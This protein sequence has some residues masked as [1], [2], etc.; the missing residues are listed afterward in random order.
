VKSACAHG[1]RAQGDPSS[2]GSGELS[3]PRPR[4]RVLRPS[5][6]AAVAGVGVVRSAV[7]PGDAAPASAESPKP[8]EAR[9]PAQA[10]AFRHPDSQEAK[11]RMSKHLRLRRNWRR[12]RRL[13]G[14]SVSRVLRARHLT[15]KALGRRPGIPALVACL[16]HRLRSE[17]AVG[18]WRHQHPGRRSPRRA[19]RDV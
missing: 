2:P 17:A 19:V 18:S 12:A 13:S 7:G 5:G 14:G 8:C 4:V 3:G 6:P 11:A 1:R 16:Q 10:G 9:S 15:S